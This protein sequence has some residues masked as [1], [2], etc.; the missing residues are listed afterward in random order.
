MVARPSE[1]RDD[2]GKGI[3]EDSRQTRL[4]A[5]GLVIAVLVFFQ[6]QVRLALDAAHS[7]E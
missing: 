1:S 2:H 5:F 4:L 3:A 6:S 7:F